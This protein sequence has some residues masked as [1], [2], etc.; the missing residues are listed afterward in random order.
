[1]S[2]EG[3]VNEIQKSIHNIDITLAEQHV[4]LKEHMRRTKMLEEDMKPVKQHVNMVQGVGAFLLI[5][6]AVIA[7]LSYHR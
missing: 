4:S 3:K 5:L 2:I 6:A 1:M 7:I